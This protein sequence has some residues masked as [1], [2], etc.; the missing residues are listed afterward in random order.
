MC[1]PSRCLETDCIT[2]LFYSCVRVWS[3]CLAMRWSNPLQYFNEHSPNTLTLF[4]HNFYW[5]PAQCVTSYSKKA[6][7]S[8]T[9]W[10]AFLWNCSLL[11]TC[12][13]SEKSNCLFTDFSFAVVSVFEFPFKFISWLPWSCKL[14]CGLLEYNMH[15][16]CQLSC[17]RGAEFHYHFILWSHEIDIN[18]TY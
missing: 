14:S 1:L 5:K 17:N 18:F 8:L 9:C 3:R 2:Q 7:S 15:A 4:L 16:Y 10:P 6:Q 11:L 12:L 13:N